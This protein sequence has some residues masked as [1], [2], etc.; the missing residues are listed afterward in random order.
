[1]AELTAIMTLSGSDNQIIAWAAQRAL[2]IVQQRRIGTI[3]PDAA[4]ISL[5]TLLQQTCSSSSLDTL[6]AY[7]EFERA[8]VDLI[9]VVS[10]AE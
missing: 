2:Q 4:V 9:V 1:M 6:D 5:E 3:T 10:N 7:D 8:V